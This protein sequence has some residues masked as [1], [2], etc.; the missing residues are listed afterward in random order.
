MREEENRAR[1]K[2]YG[3]EEENPSARAKQG[4]GKRGIGHTR[5]ARETLQARAPD[6]KASRHRKL[7]K[8][9]ILAAHSDPYNIRI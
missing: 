5:E 3:R 4:R 1:A 2:S 7:P 9:L 8:F 6:T